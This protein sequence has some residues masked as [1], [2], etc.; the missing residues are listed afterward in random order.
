MH[1]AGHSWSEGAWAATCIVRWPVRSGRAQ[2]PE[3]AE[4]ALA[5]L[6]ATPLVLLMPGRPWLRRT[7]MGLAS[8][9]QTVPALALLAL[10][11]PLLVLLRNL[12]GL[13]VPGDRKSVV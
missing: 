9:V 3:R 1:A 7:V 8:V 2:A 6:V 12:T 4:L 10:F 5:L 13:P 11:F